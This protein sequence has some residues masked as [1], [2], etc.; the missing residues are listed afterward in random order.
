MYDN[1]GVALVSKNVGANAAKTAVTDFDSVPVENLM[2]FVCRWE[3]GV[4]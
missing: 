2:V 1:R 3:V 4:D